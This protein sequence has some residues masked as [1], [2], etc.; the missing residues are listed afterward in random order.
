M[1]HLGLSEDICRVSTYFNN[2]G[3]SLREA[4]AQGTS[5]YCSEDAM[6]SYDILHDICCQSLWVQCFMPFACSERFCKSQHP[7]QDDLA[8]FL[9]AGS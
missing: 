6:L 9:K 8:L 4:P 1:W 7:R 3:L 2:Q 5:S